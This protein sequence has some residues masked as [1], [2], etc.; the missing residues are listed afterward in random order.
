MERSKLERS[1]HGSS[2]NDSKRSFKKSLSKSKNLSRSI[3][4]V[5]YDEI[6]PILN[7]QGVRNDVNDMAKD[8]RPLSPM[9][10]GGRDDYPVPVDH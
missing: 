10:N 1:A 6:S 3:K 7:F 2:V 4:N 8:D 5:H 9:F